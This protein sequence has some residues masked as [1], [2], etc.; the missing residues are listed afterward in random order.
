MK[1]IQKVVDIWTVTCTAEI[2]NKSEWMRDLHTKTVESIEL[3]LELRL[4]WWIG[5]PPNWVPLANQFTHG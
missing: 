2:E 5:E 4:D 3:E 1:V